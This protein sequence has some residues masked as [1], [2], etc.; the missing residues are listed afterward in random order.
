M[1][2][3]ACLPNRQECECM[4]QAASWTFGF[5]RGSSWNIFSYTKWHEACLRRASPHE[6]TQR[7]SGNQWGL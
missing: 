1:T 5:L 6:V 3:D 4:R 2:N 7:K